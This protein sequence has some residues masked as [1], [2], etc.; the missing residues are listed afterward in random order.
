MLLLSTSLQNV[1]ADLVIN[2]NEEPFDNDQVAIH[3]AKS[4]CKEEVPSEWM[5]SMHS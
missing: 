5:W 2:M 4:L 3:I 1:D